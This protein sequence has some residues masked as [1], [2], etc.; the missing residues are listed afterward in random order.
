LAALRICYIAQ[1]KRTNTI[2]ENTK[3]ILLPIKSQEQ[4]TAIRGNAL[5]TKIFIGFLKRSYP[6]VECKREDPYRGHS[7]R[8][9]RIW[10]KNKRP[11]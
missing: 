5:S 8:K 11:T 9:L 4:P 3:S 7:C 1:S 6:I 2:S 10:L